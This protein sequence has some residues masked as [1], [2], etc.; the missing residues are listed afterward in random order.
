[1]SSSGTRIGVMGCGAISSIYLEN[2]T[3]RISK[4]GETQCEVVSCADL[5]RTA[6]ERLASR[7][8]VPEI[9]SPEELIA[10][11]EIDLILNRTTPGAH[12]PVAR[13]AI[14]AGKHVYNEKPLAVRLADGH[15][16]LDEARHHN[17]RVGAAPDTVLGAGLQTARNVIDAGDIG[18]P[19]AGTAFMT[20]RGHES[21][22]P[23]PAFYYD[24]GG[25]PLFDMGPY[26]LTALVHLLGPAV[27]VTGSARTSFE[28]RTITSEPRRGETI[29]V[30]VPTHAAAVID[31]ACGAVIT[32]IMSFDVHRARLPIIEIYGSEG[33]LA[34]PDPNTFGGAVERFNPKSKSWE[35]CAMIG[36]LP[37]ENRR[38]LGVHDMVSAIRADRP[39]LASGEIA[40]HVLEIMHAVHRSSNVGV[41]VEIHSQPERPAAM[42]PVPS[43][44]L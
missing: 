35:A 29:E 40:L 5:D 44:W 27:R 9:C 18:Q 21:W 13:D 28:T 16:I 39:H 33:S 2:L 14:R 37:T 3:G 11:S 31:F 19:V 38:G 10:H 24:V 17:V 20:C 32:L 12:W 4:K 1:M 8:G 30:K 43:A 36:G 23:N 25:G 15:A 42:K 6:A 7:Y 22:H 34:V 41:H 26:Y